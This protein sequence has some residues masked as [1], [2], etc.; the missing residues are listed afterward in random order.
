MGLVLPPKDQRARAAAV[1]EDVLDEGEAPR[2]LRIALRLVTGLDIGSLDLDRTQRPRRRR[3]RSGQGAAARRANSAAG[4]P[5]RPSP[6]AS[7]RARKMSR[8]W[9]FLAAAYLDSRLYD[10]FNYAQASA[11]GVFSTAPGT[12]R[13]R[14]AYV[15][16]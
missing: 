6:A 16:A 15:L 11:S 14:G 8:A 9:L 12:S 2:P 4:S 1:D 13:D 7:A 3:R 10:M 5:R